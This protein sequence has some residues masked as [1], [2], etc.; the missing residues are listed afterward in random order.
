MHRFGHIAWIQW[1]NETLVFR[2]YPDLTLTFPFKS[3][4]VRLLFKKARSRFL[5]DFFFSFIFLFFILES[6]TEKMDDIGENFA[7]G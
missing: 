5:G 4:H 7:K 1:H 3:A 2:T 6:R